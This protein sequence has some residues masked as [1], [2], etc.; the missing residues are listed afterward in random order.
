MDVTRLNIEEGKFIL[1]KSKSMAKVQRQFRREFMRNPPLFIFMTSLRQM[2]L[3]MM[4]TR[5]VPED[6]RHSAVPQ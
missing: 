4:L 6:H 2:G 1:W 3:F 5:S